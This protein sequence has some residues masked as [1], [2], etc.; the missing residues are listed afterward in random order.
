MMKLQLDMTTLRTKPLQAG[1]ANFCRDALLL[2]VEHK[3]K[4][5]ES[6]AAPL[7]EFS[8]ERIE[9]LYEPAKSLSPKLFH[10]CLACT[11]AQE[12][13]H[14][15]QNLFSQYFKEFPSLYFALE[16]LML[17]ICAAE[18]EKSLLELWNVHTP[19]PFSSPSL[20]TWNDRH[21]LF[22]TQ[23]EKPQ[24]VKI[25]LPSRPPIEQELEELFLHTP[26]QLYF[27]FD[28][29]QAYSWQE[30]LSFL[31]MLRLYAPRI[32]F[33]EE[34][35]ST[36]T[37]Q[38]LLEAQAQVQEI[39]L[40]ADESLRSSSSQQ[41][42]HS[43]LVF[44]FKPSIGG[45]LLQAWQLFMK[46]YKASLP[47]VF[48]SAGEALVNFQHLVALHLSLLQELGPGL[49]APGFGVYP[50][51]AAVQEIGHEICFFG[52]SSHDGAFFKHNSKAS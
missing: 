47:T 40:A 29:N 37:I 31:N 17:E 1:K 30:G 22:H 14:L 21:R 45:G 50:E 5:C 8:H 39:V 7:P 42:E 2:R 32:E 43:P 41:D 18:Q 46:R 4:I 48:S 44:V 19:L 26:Q 52:S 28:A 33:V 15:A 25:K 6:V 35:F 16:C 51:E 49:L 12:I 3:G 10:A 11:H 36:G 9:D 13:L 23:M 38:Q 24:C 34:V 20:K 27:R